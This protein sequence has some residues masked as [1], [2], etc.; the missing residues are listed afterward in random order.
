VPLYTAEVAKLNE[1]LCLSLSA[2]S[3]HPS[4]FCHLCALQPS[5]SGALRSALFRTNFLLNQAGDGNHR[6]E[7]QEATRLTA[8]AVEAPQNMKLRT[9]ESFAEISPYGISI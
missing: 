3:S 1:R 5:R 6:S 7:N 8:N 4:H 2:S 9:D